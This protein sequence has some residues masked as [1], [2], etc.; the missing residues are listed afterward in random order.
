MRFLP[1]KIRLYA[2]KSLI[3]VILTDTGLARPENQNIDELA[4]EISAENIEQSDSDWIFYS[5]YGDPAVTGET[6]VTGGA[7]WPKLSAVK[8]GHAKAVNDD[9]WFL[10]LGP[11]GAQLIL[12]D[13]RSM[14]VG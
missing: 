6:S 10:G 8:T 2:N 4:A 14:L 12:Q 3:G 5:S 13:L 11:T 9:V 7:I 1:G